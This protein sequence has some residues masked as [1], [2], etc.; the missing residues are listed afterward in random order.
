MYG[1]GYTYVSFYVKCTKSV[2]LT[3]NGDVIGVSVH[4]LYVYAER[5]YR[6]LHQD[7][8]FNTIPFSYS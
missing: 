7:F 4:L 8:H 2:K 1:L 5:I 6:V 3:H